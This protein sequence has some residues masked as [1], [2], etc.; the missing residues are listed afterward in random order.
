M[1]RIR[2]TID[3]IGLKG[4]APAERK[5]LVEGLQGELARVLADPTTRSA[6]ARS[7]RKPALRLGQ[8]AFEP[9][10]SGGR[11]LGQGMARAMSKRLKP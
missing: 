8:M 11:K 3:E 1:S 7:F 4:F 5:A 10:S 6:S 2:V 9:G